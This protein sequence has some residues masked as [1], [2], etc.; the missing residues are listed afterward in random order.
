[1]ERAKVTELLVND[2]SN[3]SGAITDTP[4][5][6]ESGRGN[7][8]VALTGSGNFSNSVAVQ[9][10]HDQVNWVTIGTVAPDQAAPAKTQ[11]IDYPWPFMRAVSASKAGTITAMRVTLAQ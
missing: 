10:S 6:R 9:G 3:A 1:M 7:V 2:G 4:P 8:V 11:A 5:W